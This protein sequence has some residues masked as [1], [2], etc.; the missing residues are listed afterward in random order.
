MGDASSLRQALSQTSNEANTIQSSASFMM[1]LYDKSSL[2]A[3][4]E[5]RNTLQSCQTSQLLPLLYVANE[6]LQNSKRNRGNKFLEAFSPA[7]ADALKFICERDSKLVEKVRRTTKIWGDRR[8]FSTRFVGTLLKGLDT[9]RDS[10]GGS[11]S[12]GGSGSSIAASSGAPKLLPPPLPKGHATT[13]SKED[14][15]NSMYARQS[16]T[17]DSDEFGGG[18]DGDDSDNGTQIS[19]TSSDLFRS[20]KPSLLNVSNISISQSSINNS[21]NNTTLPSSTRRRSTSP[22]NNLKRR[23]SSKDNKLSN[24]NGTKNQGNNNKRQRTKKLKKK[25]PKTLSPDALVQLLDQLIQL[26]SQ[27]QNI[28][29]A[30]TAAT[31]LAA[32]AEVDVA[33]DNLVGEELVTLHTEI[34]GAIRRLGA[35][36]KESHR[37]ALQRKELEGQM[38]RY[39]VW[40]KAGLVADEEEIRLCDEVEKKLVLMEVI[41]SRAKKEREIKRDLVAKTRA[42]AETMAR[43]KEEEEKLKQSLEATLRNAQET[44][45]GMVWNQTAREFQYLP[46]VTEESW[47]DWLADDPSTFVFIVSLV[48]SSKGEKERNWRN[49]R[50]IIGRHLQMFEWGDAIWSGMG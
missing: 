30:S 9:F 5:W 17:S 27:F 13:K 31:K 18:G 41:H 34:T 42:L 10:I 3:V 21:T 1:R 20:E 32:S 38:K 37:V 22:S 15:T 8:V 28:S 49:I 11:S 24:F 45:P 48:Y 47:R 40:G 16:P 4:S 35:Q 19:S 29:S 2:L 46:D 36:E 25:R 26:E 12:R 44:Q 23:R 14:L 39:V 6:V 50:R 33:E 7:L 43:Q